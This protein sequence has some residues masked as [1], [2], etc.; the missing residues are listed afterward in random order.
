[1][2]GGDKMDGQEWMKD[3][4]KRMDILENNSDFTNVFV[5]TMTEYKQ[6]LSEGKIKNGML[7]T[8]TKLN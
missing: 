2:I 8:I 6:A 1:M 4:E 5:G 3:K 7:V